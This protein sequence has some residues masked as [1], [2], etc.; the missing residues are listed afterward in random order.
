MKAWFQRFMSGRYGNDSFSRFLCIVS[1]A[2]LLLGLFLPGVF[3]LLGLALLVYCYYRMLSRNIQR[4]Y[5][6]NLWYQRRRDA[7]VGWFEKRR[8]RFKQR[9]TYRYFRCPHCRQEIRV[10]KG[11]GKISITCPKCHNQFIKKS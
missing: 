2:L 9:S 7:V 6:E 8:L 1:L 5:A 10:P 11:R 3:Y 4:R